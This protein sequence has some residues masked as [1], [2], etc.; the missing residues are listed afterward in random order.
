MGSVLFQETKSYLVKRMRTHNSHGLLHKLYIYFLLLSSPRSS[1]H[2]PFYF[3]YPI[4][5]FTA[6]YWC[7]LCSHSITLLLMVLE[8][9]ANNL[10]LVKYKTIMTELRT[11]HF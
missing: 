11:V 4:I 7:S 1:F 10:D 5:I 9:A 2:F 3:F 6:S 8:N